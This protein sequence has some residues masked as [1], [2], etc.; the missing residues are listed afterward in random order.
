[1][2][3]SLPLAQ[4]IRN[5]RRS[6]LLAGVLVFAGCWVGVGVGE[7]QIGLFV[8]IGVVLGL[9]NGILT[10]AFL[11]RATESDDMLSRKQFAISS[12]VRLSGISLVALTLAVA[13]WPYGGAVLA[14]L[15]AFHLLALVLTALPLLKELRQ[16]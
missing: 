6:L 1:V 10:E 7:W 16:A 15:A 11:L 2:N 3:E 5:Q 8:A 13:F 12:L 9:A 14:G 4:A